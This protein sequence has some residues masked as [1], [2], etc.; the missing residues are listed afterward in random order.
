MDERRL[1]S[2]TVPPVDRNTAGKRPLL[3]DGFV[4]AALGFIGLLLRLPLMT[5]GL[6]R[7][8]GSTVVVIA[9]PSIP[10]VMQ[11]IHRTEFSPPLYYLLERLW[12]SV[13]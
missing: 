10:D 1:F 6:W 11:A 7:D 12:V 5:H 4:A 8:E 9:Q 2:T 3:N 13:A